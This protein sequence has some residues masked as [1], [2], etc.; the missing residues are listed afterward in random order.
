M[1]KTELQFKQ[2]Q[3]DK[4][5]AYYRNLSNE[6]LL[7]KYS[8]VSYLYERAVE[9]MEPYEEIGRDMYL[10]RG[11]LMDRMENPRIFKATPRAKRG[12]E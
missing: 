9:R 10:M 11:V 4:D 12:G 7:Y 5:L 8:R 3:L 1:G 2:H 6:D